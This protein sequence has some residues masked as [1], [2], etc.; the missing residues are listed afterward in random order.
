MIIV[1]LYNIG[2]PS[3]APGFSARMHPMTQKRDNKEIMRDFKLRQNR[4]FFAIG[5]TL[6]LLLFLALLHSRP[7]VFGEFSRNTIFAVQVMLIAAFI[8]FSALNWRCPACNK[9]LGHDIGRRI[10]R[11][12]GVRLR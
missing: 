6:V 4:Q 11:H 1:C 8:G 12:C 3:G 5:L 2:N 9:Y 7:N 10:C